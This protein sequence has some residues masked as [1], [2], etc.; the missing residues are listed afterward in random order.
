MRRASLPCAMTGVS[1]AHAIGMATV[2]PGQFVGGRGVLEVGA[3][4]DLIRFSVNE[5]TMTLDT[6][7]VG[8]EVWDG[9]SRCV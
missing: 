5:M 8:G 1:L 9:T 6:V 7:I 4:A 3:R 2:T